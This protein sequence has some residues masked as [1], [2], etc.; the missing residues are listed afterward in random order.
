MLRA[1]LAY[2]YTTVPEH[3]LRSLVFMR[4]PSQA[5]VE[6]V[7]DVARAVEP[8]ALLHESEVRNSHTNK[9]CSLT[10]PVMSCSQIRSLA[11]LSL[12]AI[13]RKARDFHAGAVT[14]MSPYG[15][16]A[17][18]ARALGPSAYD[19]AR[20]DAA[21]M[22]LLHS[23][24]DKVRAIDEAR[25][26]QLRNASVMAASQWRSLSS[27]TQSRW[28]AVARSLP[29]RT[30]DRLYA[31]ADEESRLRWDAEAVASIRDMIL[32]S[33]DSQ[34]YAEAAFG[35]DAVSDTASTSVPEARR[36]L[37]A[38]R[39]GEL[40]PPVADMQSHLTFVLLAYGNLGHPQALP[41]V[42]NYTWHEARHVREAAARTLRF[43]HAREGIPEA[44][45]GRR[46]VGLPSAFYTAVTTANTE[47]SAFQV[48]VLTAVPGSKVHLAPSRR[49][50]EAYPFTVFDSESAAEEVDLG[51]PIDS[52]SELL[53]LFPG[54]LAGTDSTDV[55]GHLLELVL[56]H[57]DKA[58]KA[59]AIDA[60]AELRPLRHETV[61][62]ILDLYE[63][64]F[65]HVKDWS[66]CARRCQRGN[67]ACEHVPAS[68]CRSQCEHECDTEQRL[69]RHVA[70]FIHLRVRLETQEAAKLGSFHDTAS[71]SRVNVWG[72]A[73]ELSRARA[74]ATRVT[75]GQARRLNA[76]AARTGGSPRALAAEVIPAAS[77][78]GRRLSYD[79]TNGLP[80]PA[81]MERARR[82]GIFTFIDVTIGSN[83]QK[84][85]Q[86]GSDFLGAN[87]GGIL[88]NQAQIQLGLFGGALAINI[89]DEAFAN[90]MI[91][92]WRISV[93]DARILFNAGWQYVTPLAQDLVNMIGPVGTN[94]SLF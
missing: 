16:S 12:S 24:I 94:E 26:S 82:L 88:T 65:A 77:R 90:A 53:S 87:V 8:H 73:P 11:T 93:F 1:P 62:A 2:G 67:P 49:L 64:R 18:A 32:H 37:G 39:K 27:D 68:H 45:L 75:E 66:A 76:V 47:P 4:E 36:I 48:R 69:A 46:L 17:A 81:H 56:H 38:V 28:R 22:S 23:E 10:N 13:A 63:N 20:I 61:E 91:L 92:G 29:V 84:L 83:N 21:V 19:A 43:V 60:L 3:V 9:T 72:D 42:L 50:Q 59:A 34:R 70:R 35:A 54:L 41:V 14:H 78:G 52:S 44:H 30:S 55:E 71:P 79:S 6:A 85:M 7:L 15:A 89:H 86:F 51:V 74:I 33:A 80:H 58:T 40:P 25:T 57:W 31:I 5:V